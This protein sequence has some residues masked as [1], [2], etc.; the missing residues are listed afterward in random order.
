MTD[1]I[2]VPI[3]EVVICDSIR[4]ARI[5]VHVRN[6]KITTTP[7]RLTVP[8]NGDCLIL[9][10][11]VDPDG[12]WRFPGNGISI[13]NDTD[14]QFISPYRFRS[15]TACALFDRNQ[16]GPKEF[17]YDVVLIHSKDGRVIGKDPIIENEGDG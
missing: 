6:E 11:L 4:V 16:G 13:K 14:S 10:E 7:D 12:V 5:Q 2:S 15:G 1:P 3:G 9:W 17:R 8:R